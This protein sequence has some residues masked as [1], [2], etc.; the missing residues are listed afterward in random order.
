MFYGD[1]R[2]RGPSGILVRP[3]RSPF[4]KDLLEKYDLP[5]NRKIRIRKMYAARAQ[6]VNANANFRG[7]GPPTFV[8]PLK[9]RPTKRNAENG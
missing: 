4:V 8:A 2:I 7:T 9:R 5:R 1:I 3:E 6:S